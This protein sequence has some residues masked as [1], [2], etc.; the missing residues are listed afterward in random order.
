LPNWERSENRYPGLIEGGGALQFI[1]SA[2]R[3]GDE[4]PP[5]SRV[6]PPERFYLYFL[7][8]KLGAVIKLIIVAMCLWPRWEI[9]KTALCF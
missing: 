8:N 1:H 5:V 7:L 4:S 6:V 9:A 3:D 2:L